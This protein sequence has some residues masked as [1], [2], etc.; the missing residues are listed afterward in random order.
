MGPEAV[1]VGE[2]PMY[3]TTTTLPPSDHTGVHV[4]RAVGAGTERLSLAC[5]ETSASS[6]PNSHS[7]ARGTDKRER[8]DNSL[9][10][11]TLFYSSHFD[12]SNKG[13]TSLTA[14]FEIA[15]AEPSVVP[16]D[17]SKAFKISK[18][19]FF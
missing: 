14:A 9:D 16:L 18:E 17:F 10:R 15:G 6:S 4:S 12:F 11:W 13:V 7:T 5:A 8:G 2:A 1:T 19:K 3:D